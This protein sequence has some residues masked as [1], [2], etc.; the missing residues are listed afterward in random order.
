MQTKKADHRELPFYFKAPRVLSTPPRPFKPVLPGSILQDLVLPAPGSPRFRPAC[1]ARRFNARPRSPILGAME[2]MSSSSPWASQALPGPSILVLPCNLG[3]IFGRGGPCGLSDLQ[4][5]L[6]V[7]NFFSHP[8]PVPAP[9]NRPYP[10]TAGLRLNF[11][12]SFFVHF[13]VCGIF[14]YMDFIHN[15]AQNLNINL[16]NRVACTGLSLANQ[17][18]NSLQIFNCNLLHF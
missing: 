14:H 5:L 10:D 8:R 2:A 12:H 16:K 1:P 7:F 3:G 17:S 13:N 15:C 4:E 6:L 18:H 11:Y 9:A